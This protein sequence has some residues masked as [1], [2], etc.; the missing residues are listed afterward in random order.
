MEAKIQT[1]ITVTLNRDKTTAGT[2][3][4][5]EPSGTPR[6]EQTFPTIYVQKSA[7]TDPPPEQIEV[8]I[9]SK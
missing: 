4:Y 7:L 5:K 9:R 3:V 6:H 1:G 2:V 8:T